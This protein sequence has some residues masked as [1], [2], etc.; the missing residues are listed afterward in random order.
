VLLDAGRSLEHMK[1]P[2]EIGRTEKEKTETKCCK[3]RMKIVVSEACNVSTTSQS[4][5]AQHLT[6]FF[7]SSANFMQLE[8]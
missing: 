3:H 2:P 1:I 4:G 5:R 8:E 6:Y 7:A